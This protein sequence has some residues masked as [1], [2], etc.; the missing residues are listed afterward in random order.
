MTGKGAKLT[1]ISLTQLSTSITSLNQTS[2]FRGTITNW[3]RYDTNTQMLH[4]R[5]NGIEEDKGSVE[6]EVRGEVGEQMNTKLRVGNQIIL[7]GRGG[8]LVLPKSD[9][10]RSKVVY[11]KVISGYFL[12]GEISFEISQDTIK[13]AKKLKKADVES[14]KITSDVKSTRSAPSTMA[15]DE[16][17]RDKSVEMQNKATQTRPGRFIPDSS[18]ELVDSPP[19]IPKTKKRTA[20]VLDDD[21]DQ[22]MGDVYKSSKTLKAKKVSAPGEGSRSIKRRKQ[23]EKLNWDLK[24]LDSTSYTPLQDVE[25]G[26]AKGS[27][28]FMVVIVEITKFPPREAS[29]DQWYVRLLVTD[30]TLS[31]E[32]TAL[33]SSIPTIELQWYENDEKKIPKFEERDIFVARSLFVS[34]VFYSSC[35]PQ[36][37]LTLT[38]G[39]VPSGRIKIVRSSKF[40]IPYRLLKPLELLDPAISPFLVSMPF[41]DSSVVALSQAE[42][43]HAV[44]LAKFYKKRTFTI[45]Q[46]RGEEGSTQT[47]GT[48]GSDSISQRPT[49]AAAQTATKQPVTKSSTLA[50]SQLK[51]HSETIATKS[52]STTAP[53]QPGRL[54]E[55]RDI[56][57]GVFCDV[58]GEI[59]KCH[60]QDFKLPSLQPV[61]LYITDYTTNPLLMSYDETDSTSLF[62]PGQQTL[63][64]SLFENQSEAL[65]P[66]FERSSSGWMQVKVGDFVRV[67]NLR[68]KQNESG[69]LEGTVVDDR[70]YQEK[71]YL[72]VIRKDGYLPEEVQELLR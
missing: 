30:P 38:L 66:L 8:I 56:E 59:L 68:P 16:K 12:P 2:I 15:E 60:V 45:S 33:S 42:L 58:Y 9:Q 26:I 43:D 61:N 37:E 25:T 11:E 31:T 17:K 34:H 3:Q 54:R 6:I 57:P 21:G 14:D 67:D 32:P 62:P 10:E 18:P 35:L 13:K 40:T 70:K 64:I 27:K 47:R 4:L 44:Q 29:G 51:P 41:K 22:E 48:A 23:E 36:F 28:N 63:Q 49:A 1:A 65:E 50:T 20:D 19:A 55:I 71:R 24:L 52:G 53:R 39:K 46:A 7:K 69:L 72:R 5:L